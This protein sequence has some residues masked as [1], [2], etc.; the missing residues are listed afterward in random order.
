MNIEIP[1]AL[2][3]RIKAYCD[4][5]KTEPEEFVLDAIIEKLGQVHKERRKKP[6]I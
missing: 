6:R 3:D 4:K 1:K 2:A 5:N